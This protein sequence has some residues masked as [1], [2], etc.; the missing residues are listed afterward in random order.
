ME[1]STLT[2]PVAPR[3]GGWAASRLRL[4]ALDPR[5]ISAVYLWIGFVVVFGLLKPNVYLTKVTIQLIFSDGAV[6]CVLALA[7]LIPLIAGAYDHW[8]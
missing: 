2:E 1:S 5:R 8:R 3:P 6:T 4:R 7:F